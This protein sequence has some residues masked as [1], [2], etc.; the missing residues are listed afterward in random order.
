MSQSQRDLLIKRRNA[1][2]KSY[3]NISETDINHILNREMEG[4]KILVDRIANAVE[5]GNDR[6][7]F[8]LMRMKDGK[9]IYGSL[10]SPPS[11]LKRL[12][13]KFKSMV[14]KGGRSRVRSQSLSLSRSRVRSQ[15]LSLSRSRP[16]KVYKYLLGGG[17]D[18]TP[19]FGI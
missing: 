12:S 4:N 6:A 3:P 15:S 2:R 11:T 7:K 5:E 8:Y 14:K 9:E 17:D 10:P 13:N 19:G 1:L 18:S 16:R